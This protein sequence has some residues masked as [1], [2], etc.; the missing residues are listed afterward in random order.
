MAWNDD[1]RDGRRYSGDNSRPSTSINEKE[2]QN[3]LPLLASRHARPLRPHL[4]NTRDSMMTGATGEIRDGRDG[5]HGHDEKTARREPSDG[6]RDENGTSD[7]THG[8]DETTR[9]TRPSMLIN[10]SKAMGDPGDDENPAV[11]VYRTDVR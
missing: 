1:E 10:K 3:T 6:A 5:I 9:R 7:E 2:K 11:S 4:I 8:R